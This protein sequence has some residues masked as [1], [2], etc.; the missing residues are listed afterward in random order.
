VAALDETPDHVGA[1]SAQSDH[2]ELHDI[3]L[4]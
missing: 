1:H 4:R 3:L 2:R